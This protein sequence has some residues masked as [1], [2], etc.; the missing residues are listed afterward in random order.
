[1]SAGVD[2]AT[3]K[4]FAPSKYEEAMPWVYHEVT[5]VVPV[6]QPPIDK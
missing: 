1:V 4:K 2:T 3:V 5:N 6:S